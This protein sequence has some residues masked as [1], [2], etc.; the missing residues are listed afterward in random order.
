VLVTILDQYGEGWELAH[1]KVEAVQL[2]QLDEGHFHGEEALEQ[3]EEVQLDAEQFCEVE[4]GQL[5]QLDVGVQGCG[6]LVQQ[7]VQI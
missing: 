4:R 5:L 1:V 7:Q 6:Q 2:V 3:V